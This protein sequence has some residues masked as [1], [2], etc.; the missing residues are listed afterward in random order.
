MTPRRRTAATGVDQGEMIVAES[1]QSDHLPLI[2]TRGA[3]DVVN[4]ALVALWA[5]A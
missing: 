4:A 1:I 3:A 2:A 5:R